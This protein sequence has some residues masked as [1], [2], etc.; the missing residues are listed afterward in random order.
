MARR[1]WPGQDPVGK[2]VTFDATFGPVGSVPHA[3]REIVGVV[4]DFRSAGLGRESGPE[5]Y[6]P[7]GQ[8]TWRM[9]S[10]VVRT[11]GDPLLLTNRLRQEVTA[12]DSDLSFYQPQTMDEVVSQS[13]A[14]PRFNM[15]LLV[16][17]AAISLLLA[18]VGVY[19][20]VSYSVS[21]R[22]SEIGVR[23]ALGAQ[24]RDV[25]WQTLREG[26]TL[27]AVGLVAGILG[28]LALS[29]SLEALLFGVAPTDL[30]TFLSVPLLFILVACLASYLP[31]R[32]ATRIDPVVTLRQL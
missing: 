9:V 25:L 3:A 28:A 17:F 6:F 26:T 11:A 1:F 31:A 10:V 5:M 13:V 4:R 30:F 32:R 19:G 23:L 2:R 22:T 16:V 8:V 27:T 15:A 7:Y 20:I 29:R 18:A 21:L 24:P 14:R 12:L